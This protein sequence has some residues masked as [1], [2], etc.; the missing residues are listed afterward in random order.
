MKMFI[1][2]NIDDIMN[3]ILDLV[4]LENGPVL[5]IGVGNGKL[6]QKL[7]NSGVND[8]T[9]IDYEGWKLKNI[10]LPGYSFV[11]GK[12]EEHLN[13]I[14]VSKI[15]ITNQF[16]EHYGTKGGDEDIQLIK[17]IKKGSILIFAVPN[18]NKDDHVRYYNLNEWKERYATLLNFKYEAI[19]Q[20]PTIKR[21]PNLDKIF[22]FKT[23]RK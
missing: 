23:I 16:F 18:Y 12:I 9:G 21:N 14:K 7:F 11:E 8:Y 4:S 2:T 1:T 10:Q 15:I 17:E 20:R 5:E 19:Y 3:N 22:L 6:A 13:L